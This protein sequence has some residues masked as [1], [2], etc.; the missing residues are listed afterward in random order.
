MSRD[1]FQRAKSAPVFT[2]A[3]SCAGLPAESVFVDMDVVVD[4]VHAVAVIP[5]ALGAVA[6]LHIGVVRVGNAAHSALVGVAAGLL[7]LLLRLLLGLFEVDHIG[8]G[9]PLDSGK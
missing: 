2:D 7:G 8:R 6:E 5:V 1:F 9:P 3:L 4:V